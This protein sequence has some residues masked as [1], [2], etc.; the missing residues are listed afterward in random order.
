MHV[1]QKNRCFKAFSLLAGPKHR[2]PPAPL[3]LVQVEYGLAKMGLVA[4][5]SLDCQSTL[6]DNE[7]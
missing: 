2:G 7:R 4:N 3:H 6:P 5:A 1:F